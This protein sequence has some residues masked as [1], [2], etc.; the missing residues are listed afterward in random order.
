VRVLVGRHEYLTPETESEVEAALRDLQGASPTAERAAK[1]RLARLG[2][3][4]EPAV[5]AVLARSADER[6]RA[7][8]QA[9]LA[10][11]GS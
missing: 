8:A 3:F 6:V 5:R 7:H 9:L 11:M 2:R 10:E 1:E 4:T